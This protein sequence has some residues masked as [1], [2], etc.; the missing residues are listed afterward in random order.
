M[1]KFIDLTGKRFGKLTVLN[2]APDFGSGRDRETMWRCQCDC[3]K[4]TDVRGVSLR[5]GHTRS[6]GCL[7]PE[8]HVILHGDCNSRLYSIWRAMRQRCKNPKSGVYASYGGRGITV[9][10]EWDKSYE[11]FRG[12]ALANG[13]RDDLTIDRIDVNGN[14]CPE[15]CRWADLPTQFNNKRDSIR[16]VYNGE[17]RSI[18]EWSEI[19]GISAT[20]IR[21]RIYT[22]K[23]SAEKA[24]S[25]PV[26]ESY[27]LRSEETAKGR[28]R[29]YFWLDDPIAEKLSGLYDGDI[30]R[31]SD[32]VNAILAQYLGSPS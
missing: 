7:Q 11:T 31:M 13:Y 18:R 9:C 32:A 22:R 12:W 23:W 24:L 28:R 15:N 20:T 29:V 8:S 2:R 21:T 10:P 3:G 16:L 1:G 25:T 4:T 30:V 14:Y 19:T 5:N 27:C 26:S 17:S 6:C